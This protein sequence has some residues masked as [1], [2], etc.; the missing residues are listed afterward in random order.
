MAQVIEFY[1]R[2]LSPWKAGKKCSAP[3][4]VIEFRRRAKQSTLMGLRGLFCIGPW[5]GTIPDTTPPRIATSVSRSLQ[6]AV[7][8]PY[9]VRRT[10][11]PARQMESGVARTSPG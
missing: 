11:A 6:P 1:V 10:S 7:S 4:R 5:R 3:A 9:L 2:D 8:G